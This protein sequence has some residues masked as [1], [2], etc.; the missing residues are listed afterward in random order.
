[1]AQL[2]KCPTRGF[3]S[4]RD[5]IVCEFKPC[6]GLCAESTGLLGIISAAPPLGL[7][8]SLKIIL[9]FNVYLF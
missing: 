5:L 8:L 7:T 9:F 1:M 4:G 6:I 2:V 3:G